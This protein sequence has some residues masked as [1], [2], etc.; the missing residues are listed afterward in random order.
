MFVF[1]S[2]TPKSVEKHGGLVINIGFEMDNINGEQFNETV[3]VISERANTI[4]S[5]LFVVTPKINKQEIEVKLPLVVLDEFQPEVFTK[6]GEL[7][8]LETYDNT[9]LYKILLEISAQL[10]KNI[11]K[12]KSDLS[13]LET[14]NEKLLFNVLYPNISLKGDVLPGSIIGRFHYSDLEKLQEYFKSAE[15]RRVIPSDCRFL[16]SVFPVDDYYTLHAVK[17]YKEGKNVNYTMIE[18]VRSKIAENTG[19]YSVFID[20]KPEYHA[21]WAK[22]TKDNVSRSLAIVI[23]DEVYSA[24][25]V[26]SEITGGSMQIT[27]SFNKQEAQNME[28]VLKRRVLPVQ[29]NIKSVKYYAPGEFH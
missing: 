11:E 21:L 7:S 29:T 3:E 19:M 26:A 1:A 13:L 5:N 28:A 2:C 14:N 27:G 4:S 9:E 22:Q 24:P 12:N 23:D 17:I 10:E 8:I 20:L 25:T 18:S 15:L 16:P 6:K